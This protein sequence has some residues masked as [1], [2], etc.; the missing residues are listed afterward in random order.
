LSENTQTGC[1]MA[2][3]FDLLPDSLQPVVVK[4]LVNLIHET[5]DHLATGF[6]GTTY[7]MQALSDHGQTALAYTLLEQES[8]PSWLYFVKEGARPYGRNGMPTTKTEAFANVPSTNMPM[9]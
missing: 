9:V 1:A 8:L 2:L 4:Q 6:L 3:A 5:D 7:I